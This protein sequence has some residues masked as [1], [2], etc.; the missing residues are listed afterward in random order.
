[1]NIRYISIATMVICLILTI[2]SHIAHND[3]LT[4]L[5]CLGFFIF[6]VIGINLGSKEIQTKQYNRKDVIKQFI[7]DNSIT[8]DQILFSLGN[9][10]SISFNENKE[11]IYFSNGN[12][13]KQYSFSDI[14]ESRIE[15]N[16]ESITKTSR[17]SQIGGAIVGGVIAGGVG[18][19]IGGLSGEK[20]NITKIK[21]LE[22]V[23]VVNDTIHPIHKIK[24]F[25]N[26]GISPTDKNYVSIK[27]QVEHWHS[28]MSVFIKQADHKSKT[29]N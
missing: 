18:A 3:F 24:L 6:L 4:I 5:F 12:E 25:S 13:I 27:E 9:C 19:V 20:K 1:M 22:L 2:V 14:I 16:G 28:L 23:I 15:E 8:Y 10:D 29:S 7:S 26:T 17:G 21:S 11:Q